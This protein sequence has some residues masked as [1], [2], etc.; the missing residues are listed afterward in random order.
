MQISTELV[1]FW[2]LA[3]AAG[4]VH[5]I[6]PD[7]WV[8]ASILSWQRRWAFARTGAFVAAIHAAHLLLGFVIFYAF[9]DIMARIPP[10][11]LFI[12][13]FVL[14]ATVAVVRALRFGR[15]REVVRSGTDSFWGGMAVFSLLGPCESVIPVFVKGYQMGSGYLAPLLAFAAGTL[16]GA[17]CLTWF[18]QLIWRQPRLLPRG[19]SWFQERH[20]MIPLSASIAVGIMLLLRVS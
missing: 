6:A 11:R 19:L 17:V 3:F 1:R 13:A 12:F 16:I 20:K 9:A 2:A 10:S 5:V 15:I 7:H 4:L 8:P 18:G 14:V